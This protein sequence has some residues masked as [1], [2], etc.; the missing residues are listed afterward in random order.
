MLEKL[1][2]ATAQTLTPIGLELVFP[3]EHPSS[4]FTAANE[5]THSTE[6]AHSAKTD[7]EGTAMCGP[8]LQQFPSQTLRLVGLW[9]Q[10]HKVV[11][12][13]TKLWYAICGEKY[14]W[15]Q[16]NRLIVQA[17]ECFEQAQV[18]KAHAVLQ[19]LCAN[20]IN[21]LKSLANQQEN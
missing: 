2:C 21:A 1:T 19:G 8:K 18:F 6:S 11:F 15:K 13:T 20:L 12:H 14:N 16:P 3:K 5:A 7:V 4:G 17:G 10:E 9:E